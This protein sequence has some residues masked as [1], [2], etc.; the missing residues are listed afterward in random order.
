MA[1]PRTMDGRGS[2]PPIRESSLPPTIC[3]TTPL[4]VT[5]P[6][7]E[8]FQR[9]IY[10]E[11]GIWLANSKKA[12]LCG[13]LARRLRALQVATLADYHELV[14]RP[15]QQA[16]RLLMIEAITTNETHFFREPKHFEFLAQEL[17]PRWQA[18]AE[19]RQR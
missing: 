16:E 17:L 3:G 15:E 18:K 8:C 1:E 12:L 4:N 10:S 2:R 19:Q 13:R 7:F 5:E 11:S 9:L 14:T 6:L